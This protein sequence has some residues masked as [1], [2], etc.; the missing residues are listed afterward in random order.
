MCCDNLNQKY[1]VKVTQS[2]SL[3]NQ[4]MQ[5][6]E[7][8]FQWY[9]NFHPILWCQKMKNRKK[10]KLITFHER[11]VELIITKCETKIKFSTSSS[12]HN[13]GRIIVRCLVAM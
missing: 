13:S 10:K 2:F 6:H 8:Y 9:V 5:S 11:I 4:V 12:P 7:E 1:E 3:K